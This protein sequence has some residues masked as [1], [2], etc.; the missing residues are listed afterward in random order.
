MDVVGSA[1]RGVGATIGVANLYALVFSRDCGYL[2]GVSRAVVSSTV[3]LRL[4]GRLAVCRV[5]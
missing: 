2:F 1:V 4:I 3:D 5:P